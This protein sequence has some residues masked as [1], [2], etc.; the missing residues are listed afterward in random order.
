MENNIL[1][2]QSLQCSN[3]PVGFGQ[4]FINKEQCCHP[5]Y[6]PDLHAADFY[7][8]LR[9]KPALKGRGFCNVTDIIKMVKCEIEKNTSDVV[10]YSFLGNSPA[11]E[12]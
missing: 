1:V 7:L 8:F 10:I 11:S 2:S 4:R 3:T 6:S 12:I 9:L 5:P